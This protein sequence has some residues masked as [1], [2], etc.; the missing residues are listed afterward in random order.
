MVMN[1]VTNV[2]IVWT[3]LVVTISMELVLMV[4]NLDTMEILVKQVSRPSLLYVH[5]C[6]KSK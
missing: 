2:D 3:S 5:L 4:V 1:A 6:I